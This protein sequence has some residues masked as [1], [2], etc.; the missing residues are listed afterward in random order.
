MPMKATQGSEAPTL[1][2]FCEKH[3]PVRSLCITHCHVF[4]P[5]TRKNRLTSAT[6]RL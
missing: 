4:K 1:A 3:L 6:P 5:R 2:C